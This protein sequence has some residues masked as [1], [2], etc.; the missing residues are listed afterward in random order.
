MAK[1]RPTNNTEWIES[2][3]G[4]DSESLLNHKCNKIDKNL[5]SLPGPNFIDNFARSE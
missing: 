4:K 1:S 5:L 3:I 2:I